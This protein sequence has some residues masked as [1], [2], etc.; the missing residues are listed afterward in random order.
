ME[1][2]W[3]RPQALAT[4]L[5][6]IIAPNPGPMTGRGTNTWLV[7]QDE[8]AVIDPGPAEP[9]HIDAILAAADGRIRRIFTTHTHPDHSPAARALAAA[10]GAV[11]IGLPPPADDPHQDYTFVP[12][13]EPEDGESFRGRDFS[14]RAIHTPGHVSN[15]VCYLHEESGLLMTGDHIMQGSTVVIIPPAGDM[16]AYLESL[17]KLLALPLRGLAPGHGELILDPADE[18]R[19]LI[20]HRL[21]REEKLLQV[22]ARQGGTLE[23]LVPVVY[24]DVSPSL[25]PIAQ[26]SL[27]AHLLKLQQEQRVHCGQ[28]AWSLTA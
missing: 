22:L 18:I 11:C 21:W 10:T 7:G 17:H 4:G 13:H 23:V 15:H 19:R 8:L 3:G 24:D 5:Q 16:K 6:R 1:H 2:P 27:H 9:A 12:A 25:H 14:L 26:F 28:G 20:R